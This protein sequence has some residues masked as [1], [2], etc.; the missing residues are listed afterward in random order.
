MQ[1]PTLN[2]NSGSFVQAVTPSD[3]TFIGVYKGKPM[4]QVIVGGA[5]NLV[6]KDL[7]GNSATIAVVAGQVL[8]LGAAY[9]MAAT[10][11]TGVVAVY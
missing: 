5:G 3:S 6:V 4:L 9:I 2:R 1:G 10:T 7:D 11:A 8:F